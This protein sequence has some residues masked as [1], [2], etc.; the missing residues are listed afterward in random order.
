[1][2]ERCKDCRVVIIPLMINSF[3]WKTEQLCVICYKKQNTQKITF[4]NGT[5]CSNKKCSWWGHH[6]LDH[7]VKGKPVCYDCYSFFM[8]YRIER[9][10]TKICEMDE[11]SRRIY[12]IP[13]LHPKSFDHICRK[14]YKQC[15]QEGKTND[16]K[17]SSCLMRKEPLTPKEQHQQHPPPQSYQNSQ[18][19]SKMS[20]YFPTTIPIID[21]SKPF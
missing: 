5:N 4:Q 12:G 1:M 13:F 18:S 14:C 15:V 16:K 11:C 21:Y 20:T 17:R 10:T 3:S 6:F 2:A 8:L 9:R 7:P 19:F